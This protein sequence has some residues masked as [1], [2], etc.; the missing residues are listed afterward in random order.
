MGRNPRWGQ[1]LCLVD[2][3]HVVQVV[4]S[5][6]DK[7]AQQAKPGE[8]IADVVDRIEVTGLREDIFSDV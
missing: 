7:T 2:G 4:K 1:E 5:F 3:S 8:R 6:L